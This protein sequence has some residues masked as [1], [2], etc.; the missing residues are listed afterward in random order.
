M[1]FIKRHLM[2]LAC[3]A[4]GVLSLV[5][6]IL[7]VLIGS[8]S[9]QMQEAESLYKRMS[10]MTRDGVNDEHIRQ[11]Q[12][13][14][15]KLAADFE[16]VRGFIRTLNARKPLREHVFPAPRKQSDAYA[17]R[18]AYREAIDRLLPE[19]LKAKSPPTAD[20][21]RR[22]GLLIAKEKAD[23]ARS[24]GPQ[25]GA[26]GQPPAT[27]A[28]GFAQPGAVP[29]RLPGPGGPAPEAAAQPGK[30]PAAPTIEELARTD[31]EVRMSLVRAHETL[32][33]ATQPAL[34]IVPGLLDSRD[35]P[36][37]ELMWEAQMSLWIQQDVLSALAKLNDAAAA[38]L[39]PEDR[40]V[41]YTPVKELVYI[42]I[43]DYVVGPGAAQAAGAVA[44]SNWTQAAEEP[45]FPPGDASAVFTNHTSNELYDVMQFAV[46][47]V[48][49]ARELPAVVD[50][51]CGANLYIPLTIT[52]SAP[53]VNPSFRGKVYGPDPVMRVRI[54]MEGCFLREFYHY[55]DGKESKDENRFMP[56]SL[57]KELVSGQRATRDRP[58]QA[59]PRGPGPMLEM[60]PGG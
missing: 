52:G 57:S 28:P 36:T 50:A 15:K 6:L 42:R 46:E 18:E 17:F 11:A 19:V 2:L 39:K 26:P 51:I 38:R 54:E 13:K 9:G 23:A 32:C 27:G 60:R 44:Q 43:G 5:A 53:A 30:P 45:S 56:E 16:R 20:E 33:Y 14:A 59:A 10:S 48:I 31:P 47:L 24:T 41:A 1:A 21:Y 40:W 12:E 58:A 22:M 7:G 8:V 55:V 49:D 35:V 4:L 25:G 29:G 37:V 34:H 3:G